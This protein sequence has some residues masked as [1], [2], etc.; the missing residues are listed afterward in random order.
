MIP[1][2]EIRRLRKEKRW[3]Q[4]DLAGNVGVTKTTI[5]DWEKGRY[6][7]VGPHV[8]ALARALGVS[9]A[10]VM[11]EIGDGAPLPLRAVARGPS[12]K[13]PI[14]S[15][16]SAACAGSG[17]SGM[18]QIVAEAEG[19]LELPMAIL[20]MISPDSD[21]QPFIISVEGD[22]MEEAD[23]PDG[24]QIVIN[25]AEEVRNGDAALVCY[26]IHSDV[27]VKWVYWGKDRSVEIRSASLRYP[28]RTFDREEIERGEI[29]VL[30]KV[31]K[32][33]GTPRRGA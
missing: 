18:D 31:V 20:G 32:T 5:L 23:I 19:E 7:P 21:K 2:N 13:V 6:S 3:T 30:G 15:R 33:L 26:G 8:G 9:V 29:R 12:F 27:A 10:Y 1:G 4:Q 17:N 14:L 28:P 22:S 16:A 11:G 24:C 25:P